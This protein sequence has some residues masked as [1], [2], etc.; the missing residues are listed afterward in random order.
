MH[1][2]FTGI[3]AFIRLSR[4]NNS[5]LPLLAV[6]AGFIG[7]HITANT[8]IAP[9]LLLS[10]LALLVAHSVVTVWNDL[11]DEAAD[12]LNGI[13]RIAALRETKTLPIV[14][15]CLWV[16]LGILAALSVWLP[17]AVSILIA[18]YLVLGWLYN[19]RPFLLSRRPIASIVVM[20]LSYGLVPFLIGTA[21]LHMSWR[22]WLL[23]L[24]WTAIR[25]S[26]SLLKDYKDAPGDAKAGKKTF[27]LVYGH[28]NVSRLQMFLATAGYA[29]CVAA[30]TLLTGKLLYTP[31]LVAVTIWLLIE[32]V[33]LF[34][35]TD[36]AAMNTLFHSLLMYEIVFDGLIIV[37][38]CS[39]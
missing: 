4:T 35:L 12:K 21:L 15:A 13:H 36:Y 39:S 16:S 38:L 25:T 19:D 2:V 31:I 10:C 22:I 17:H 33:K 28:S 20:A 27:L 1:R 29:S 24:G 5:V 37:W 11:R 18:S 9:T 6:I 23:A 7:T 14:R 26:I 32:R 30:T 8:S 34:R 3:Q